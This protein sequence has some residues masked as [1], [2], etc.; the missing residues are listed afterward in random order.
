VVPAERADLDPAVEALGAAF[1]ADP[2]ISFLF[3]PA[4]E[5]RDECAR[6]FFRLLLSARLECSMPALIAREGQRI[7]GAVMGYDTSR[8]D[9][10]AP[11]RERWERLMTGVP[12]LVER[13]GRYES[14]ADTYMPPEPHYYLGV[15]GVAPGEQG[16]GI[17]ST[18]LA[19]FCSLSAA[20]PRSAGVYLETA[21]PANLPLYRRGG[22]AVTGEGTLGAATLWCMYHAHEGRPRG[23]CCPGS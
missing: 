17:G 2:L 6:E 10:P 18:L 19:S 14:L 9:W 1:A 16:R 4:Q 3:A 22:F 8:P 7:L 12:A 5:R 15:L 20:D 21:N 11:L 23:V 13:L